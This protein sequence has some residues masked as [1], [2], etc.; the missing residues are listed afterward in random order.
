MQTSPFV[1]PEQI[2]QGR[3]LGCT[4]RLACIVRLASLSARAFDWTHNSPEYVRAATFSHSFLELRREEVPLHSEN[5]IRLLFRLTHRPFESCARRHC[6]YRK[7]P[8][9][10]SRR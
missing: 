2:V 4:T 8:N 5:K 9:V 6:S 3:D 1:C 10:P 7:I